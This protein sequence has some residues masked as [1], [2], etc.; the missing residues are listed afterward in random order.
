MMLFEVAILFFFGLTII[1]C[2]IM[3]IKLTINKN[4]KRKYIKLKS[5]ADILVRNAIFYDNNAQKSAIPVT[6]RTSKMLSNSNF[7]AILVKE[8]LSAK[9]NIS[10]TSATNLENLYNQLNLDKYASKK[11]KDR[12]W[13]I[14]AKAIQELGIMGQKKY[15]NTIYRATNSKNELVRMEAQITVVKMFGFEGLR[16]LDVVSYQITEWQQIQLMQ[17]L[18]RVSTDNFSGIEKWLDSDNQSVVVFALKLV[19]NYHRFELY[20]Q[21]IDL[22]YH[23]SDLVRF[24]AIYTL[25]KIYTVDTSKILIDSYAQ[26]T[27]NNRIAIVKT[28]QL[29]GFDDDIPKL[30]SFLEHE[31]DNELKRHIV[32]TIAKISPAGL[33]NISILFQSEQYPLDQIV[34]QIEGEFA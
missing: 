11:L 24:E 21:V 3:F 26:E 18:S 31:N 22:L 19:R 1:M 32:R 13:H 14:K 29:I 12:R 25:G 6:F 16:F 8:L 27:L 7:R 9:K 23:K 2:C 17:E 20:K 28:L 5:M 30:I 33:K 4:R 34:K 15:L 10:G